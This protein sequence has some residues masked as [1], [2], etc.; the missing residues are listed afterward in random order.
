M[1]LKKAFRKLAFQYHPDHNH[2]D[3]A[4]GEIQGMNEAYEVLATPP[5]FRLMTVS[6]TAAALTSS[7]RNQ[8]VLTLGF[9]DIFEAFL[10]R[11]RCR[12][13]TGPGKR[14]QSAI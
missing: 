12:R 6:G 1:G 3:G 5:A 4:L 9:G 14:R 10:W 7:V 8:M 2:E 11:Q 13:Q